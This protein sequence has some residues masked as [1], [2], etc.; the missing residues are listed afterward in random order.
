MKISIITVCYNSA[1][2]VRDALESVWQQKRDGVEIEYIVVDGK[3][4][5]NT[6][7]IIKEFERKVDSHQPPATNHQPPVTSHQPPF[8]F[9]W[10]SEPDDGLYD[11]MNKGMKMATGELIGIVN[12]D[13]MLNSPDVLERVAKC[14]VDGTEVLGGCVR[15]VPTATRYEN[16]NET[17]S[18]RYVN[19]RL[20]K[21]WMLSWGYSS[22]SRL[23]HS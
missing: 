3:S 19:P 20:W 7:E 8:T 6:V 22:A 2:T 16:L 1:K 5:D 12:S 14:A 4:K 11:A 17:P 21:K 9:K 18:A 15:F 10:I 13:D 23:V